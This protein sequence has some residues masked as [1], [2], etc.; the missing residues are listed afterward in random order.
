[1]KALTEEEKIEKK[2]AEWKKEYSSVY[3]VNI[4]GYDFIFKPINRAEYRVLRKEAE[5]IDENVDRL[6][7]RLDNEEKVVKIA[8]LYPEEEELKNILDSCGGVANVLSDW[9]M[10]YSGFAEEEVVKL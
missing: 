5:G 3:K 8:T 10:Y 7:L 6:Q 4:A 2:I 1:M 9:I